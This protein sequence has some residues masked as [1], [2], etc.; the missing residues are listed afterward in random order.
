MTSGQSSD[1]NGWWWTGYIGI[2]FWHPTP[3]PCLILDRGWNVFW[4]YLSALKVSSALAGLP[5]S[6][7][8][9]LIYVRIWVQIGL[10]SPQ[11]VQLS[12][13]LSNC[14]NIKLSK[15][16]HVKMSDFFTVTLSDLLTVR[17]S[18]CKTVNLSDF[19]TVG[20][21]DCLTVWLSDFHTIILSDCK[22]VRLSD[23]LT[24]RLSD[25]QTV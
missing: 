15:C 16:Q 17:M 10:H 13:S 2:K 19:Q 14:Q 18:D 25:C 1:P 11:T 23:C 4:F 12:D 3:I 22:T 5:A 21:L 24:V 6:D 7:Q 8:N 20:L 9:N